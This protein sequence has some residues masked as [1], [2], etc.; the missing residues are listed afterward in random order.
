MKPAP[1]GGL[2]RLD[3]NA[4]PATFWSLALA[5]VLSLGSAAVAYLAL[6]R[7]GIAGMV[8]VLAGLVGIII[9]GAV[10]LRNL[11]VAIAIWLFTMGGVRL[12][13]LVSMPGL[14]DFSIDR[15]FL[16]WIAIFFLIHIAR[17][18]QQ[19]QPPYFADIMIISH[20]VYILFNLQYCQSPYFNGW[21]HSSLPPLF[22]FLYGH[23]LV[24]DW[25]SVRT[26][27]VF[28]ALMALYFDITAIAEQMGWRGLIWPKQ[29]LDPNVGMWAPGR[30]R[31]PV[32]H[33]PVFGQLLSMY[34]L[35]FFYLAT[36]KISRFLRLISGVM[37][38]LTLL[39]LFLTYT[40][41]PWLAAALAI[42]VVA[43]LRASYRRIV[44]ALV[45]V[46]LLVGVFGVY[47]LANTKFLQSRVQNTGTV[48]NRLSFLALEMRMVRDHPLL[49]VGYLRSK[50]FVGEYS[51]TTTIPFYGMIRKGR[52]E[53]MVAHDIYL[54]RLVEEG[55]V[56]L[57]LMLMF[58]VA[59]GRAW[60]RQWRANP[61]EAWF[62]RDL[63]ALFAG[64]MVSYYFGGLI[65]DYRYFDLV[66]VVFC[67]I[68]GIVYGYRSPQYARPELR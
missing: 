68:G 35:L 34:V 14:P 40:R 43:A 8:L 10:S 32:V 18:R 39:A 51:K 7:L 41:G 53:G 20:T 24:K 56:G 45:V 46:G 60:W 54:G 27:V 13:S 31:G 57:G 12:V 52:S 19:L 49:G 3:S 67:L 42:G 63:L 1:L 5:L 23:Y 28:L 59:I 58:Y 64:M 26:L 29:I 4:S 30:A 22:A 17:D 25:R 50:E 47:R 48:E 16:V 9:L 21:V 38:L 44:L 6:N 55:L 2:P 36:R 65:I 15:F 62:D 61:Q 33:P 66:N 11:I 37:V